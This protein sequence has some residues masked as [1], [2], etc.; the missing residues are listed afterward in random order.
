MDG[1]FEGRRRRNLS[2]TLTP[3]IEDFYEI[4]PRVALRLTCNFCINFRLLHLY[5]GQCF[6]VH[7]YLIQL[8]IMDELTVVHTVFSDCRVDSG[9]P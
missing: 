2:Q 8:Q 5:V 6:P 4:R 1:E 7:L 9:N 3:K